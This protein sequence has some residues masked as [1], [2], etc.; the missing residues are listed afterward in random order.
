[1]SLSIHHADSN[2]K[3]RQVLQGLGMGSPEARVCIGSAQLARTRQHNC[4][5]IDGKRVIVK[6]KGGTKFDIEI[7]T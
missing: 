1:M 5:V 2:Y 7:R 4:G 6:F 3:A